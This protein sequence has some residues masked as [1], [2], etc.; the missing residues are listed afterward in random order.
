MGLWELFIKLSIELMKASCGSVEWVITDIDYGLPLVWHQAIEVFNTL[1][2]RQIQCH[3]TDVIFKYIFWNENV[4]I[5]LKIWLK[6]V[7]SIRINNIPA[8]VQK[9]SWRRP[10]DKP[11]SEPNMV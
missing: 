4:Q 9:M 3:F 5:S 2:Q 1:R 6:S 11:L 8:L 7:S 10:G